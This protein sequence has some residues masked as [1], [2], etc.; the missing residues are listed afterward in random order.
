M[1]TESVLREMSGQIGGLIKEVEGMRRD[2]AALELKIG[3]VHRRLDDIVDEAGMVRADIA[4]FAE[5]L[6]AIELAHKESVIPTV[7]KVR[8]W[9]QRGIGA[10]AVLGLAF[11]SLGVIVAKFWH[12]ILAWVV[13]MGR[14]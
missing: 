13:G 11:T 4:G 12:E 3:N 7:D 6:E 9:E 14:P 2:G 10:A 5:R 8:A 1:T